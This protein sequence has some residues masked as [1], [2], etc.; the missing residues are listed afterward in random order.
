[1]NEKKKKNKAGKLIVVLVILAVVVGCG[2]YWLSRYEPYNLSSIRNDPAAQLQKSFQKTKEALEEGIAIPLTDIPANALKNGMIQWNVTGSDDG[3]LTGS[4]YV[5]ENGLVV[6]G[7]MT[8]PEDTTTHYGMWLTQ[9][10]A[11][12]QI[13]SALDNHVYGIDLTTLET[14]LK[15]SAI[16]EYLGISY[17]DALKSINAATNLTPEKAAME[18]SDWKTLLQTKEKLE[19]LLASCPVSVSSG[20]LVMHA[21]SA[22]VYCV[23]YTITPEQLC[24][25]LDL[26][27]DWLISTESYSQF[28]DGSEEAKQQIETSREETKKAI[29]DTNATTLLNVFL[30]HETQVIVC[31]ELKTVWKVG[32]ETAS[33][34]AKIT[35]GADPVKSVLYSAEMTMD[36]PLTGKETLKIEYNRSHAHNLPGRTL[37]VTVE[38]ETTTVMDL[39]YNTLDGTFELSLMDG[40]YNLTGI[41]KAENENLTVS[42]DLPDIGLLN[43]TFVENAQIP[44]VPEYQNVFEMNE[45]DQTTLMEELF[46]TE[47]DY[48]YMGD[49]YGALEA[50]IFICNTDGQTAYFGMYHNYSTL[51]ELLVAEE[52]AELDQNGKIVTICDDSFQNDNWDVYVHLEQ[53]EGSLYDVALDDYTYVEIIAEEG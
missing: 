19:D 49:S 32:D 18:G 9:D 38:D 51:G 52:I 21:E 11:A 14:D 33:S 26:A 35:L 4:L 44:A 1:M 13:P 50:D 7:D 40:E 29:I 24:G 25:A 39:L 5:R 41:Y 16:L 2:A 37:V 42:I 23:S 6:T 8:I 30:H 20:N 15:D 3:S 48:G 45:E 34:T 17:E 53:I 31:A 36:D 12:I 22:E 43:L 27:Y 46:P 10:A 28:S 47:P